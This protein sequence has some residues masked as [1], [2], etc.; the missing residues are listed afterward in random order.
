MTP[1]WLDSWLAW[2][3]ARWRSRQHTER[4]TREHDSPLI[5]PERM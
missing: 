5:L 2:L 3:L 1:G 4:E